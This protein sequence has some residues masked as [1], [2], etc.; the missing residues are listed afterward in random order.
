[1]EDAIEWAKKAPLR[2]ATLEVRQL[3][4]NEDFGDQMTDELK[5][6]EEELRKKAEERVMKK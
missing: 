6:K 1:M 3:H 2:G 5:A 4:S